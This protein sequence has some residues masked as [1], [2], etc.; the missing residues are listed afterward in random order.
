M[1]YLMTTFGDGSTPDEQQ[2]EEMGKFVAELS[3]SGVL[4]AAGG[5]EPGGIH[6]TSLGSEFTVTDGPFTEAKEAAGGF[7]LVEVSSR[8]EAIE[9]T[10]RAAAIGGDGTTIIQ[11]VFS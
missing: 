1:R 7:A 5:L 6:V 2:Y 8:E 10:R 9:L 11:Q 4:L 3:A